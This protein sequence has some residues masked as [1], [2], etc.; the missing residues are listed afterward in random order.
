MQMCQAPGKWEGMASPWAPAA[1]RATRAITHAGCS[2]LVHAQGPQA[3][4]AV[5][6]ELQWDFKDRQNLKP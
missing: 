2:S 4:R 5:N 6:A 3:R 1:L